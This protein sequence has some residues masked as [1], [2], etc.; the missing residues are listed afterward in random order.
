MFVPNRQA[1]DFLFGILGISYACQAAHMAIGATCH[2][3]KTYWFNTFSIGVGKGV[4]L[5]HEEFENKGMLFELQNDQSASFATV[6]VFL[7]NEF[8]VGESFFAIAYFCQKIFDERAQFVAI[9]C[10]VC[11]DAMSNRSRW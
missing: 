3:E 5:F 6:K 8:K 10:V 7:L 1:I 4:R 11:V 9:T 2:K